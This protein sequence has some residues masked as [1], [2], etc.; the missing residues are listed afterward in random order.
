M[1]APLDTSNPSARSGFA[2]RLLGPVEVLV[3]GAAQTVGSANQRLVLAALLLEPNQVVPVERLISMLWGE[4]PPA[5]ART[6][7]QGCVSRLRRLF[8]T[9]AADADP[10]RLATRAP[11]YALHV[12][13]GRIDLHRAR[14]LIDQAH[15][16]QLEE[17]SRSLAAALR[18]W[19]GPVLADLAETPL[20]RTTAP[21]AEELRL[22]ALEERAA[23]D[24]ELGRHAQLV[25]ELPALV[26]RHPLRERLATQLMLAHYRCGQRAQ[27][28]NCFHALRIRLSQELGIDPG[29]EVR[30]LYERMLRDD[31]ALLG[32][33]QRAQTAHRRPVPAELPPAPAGFVGRDEEIAELDGMLDASGT[34]AVSPIAVITGTAG[35]GKSALAVHW[36]RRA[37]HAFP[38][39][40]LHV[41]LRGFDPER[42]PL[43]AGEALTS[44]L[45]ALGMAPD[46]IPVDL[47]DRTALYR[48]MLAERQVLLV[49]DNA[50]DS[51][52]VR[53]LLPGNSASAVVVTSRRR[54]D[55]LVVR[56]G[57]RVF[58]LETLP[59][60]AAVEVLAHAGDVAA[61][62]A[63]TRLAELCGGL[64]LALRI[65]AARVQADPGGGAAGVVEELADERNRL[66]VLDTDDGETS[67]RGAFDVSYRSLPAPL[68]RT[69]RL[70]GQVPGPSVSAFAA[71]ALCGTD[72]G[73][74]RYALRALGRAH[75]V[76]ESEPDRFGMHDLLRVYAREAEPLPAE[77]CDAAAERDERVEA[78]R[79]LVH[80]YLAV[81]D[82]ARRYLRP[83]RDELRFAERAA[84]E[85]PQLADRADAL[86]WFDAEWSNLVALV[87]R[88]AD[89]GFC[90]LAWRLVR[91]QFNY[92]MVRCPWED[93]IALYRIGLRAA[94]SAGETEGE[95]LMSAGLGVAHSRSGDPEAALEHYRESYRVAEG[96][97]NSSWLAMARVNL[98]SVLIRLGRHEQAREHCRAALEGRCEQL[99]RY[100]GAGALNNLAQV[101]QAAGR[102]ELALRH[103]REA[104]ELYREMDDLETLAMVLNNCGEVHIEL[105]RLEEGERY[106]SEALE[107]ALRCGSAMRQ[108]AAHVGLGDVAWHRGDA[109]VA[110]TRW[111]TALIVFDTGGSPMGREVRARLA[112]FSGPDDTDHR[113]V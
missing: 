107:V 7:V 102:P 57:A 9:P 93:W 13:P 19:R 39:G 5:T 94:R 85:R 100:F 41:P 64:P 46:A 98:A 48:S 23:A 108:A 30:D 12:D 16:L 47:D 80:Y 4:E 17:R 15:G 14:A 62:A 97:A 21:Q 6:I 81:S 56:G 106:H 67:V 104:E 84:V 31:A 65:A 50:R 22:A 24:L 68:A 90:E 77:E 54:L 25:R 96:A 2:F 71:A 34:R 28:Q 69:F 78:L 11:G 92:L 45:K 79:R 88:A 52:Q 32:P 105:C 26:A 51:E 60:P 8:S 10:P 27:A 83:A 99:D 36:G 109:S 37:A 95:V 111:N 91:M 29:P 18:L 40:Q 110:R 74:A 44:V 87:R 55:G 101:E 1:T 73:Q 63:A 58:P 66:R 53:P 61:D 89:A 70:L 112:R 113:R 82:H 49:L 59:A 33:R 38:D 75:L 43:A 86:G 76:G 103:L 35:V 3:D 42:P 20:G 72:L